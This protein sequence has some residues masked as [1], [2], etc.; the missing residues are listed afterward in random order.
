[1]SNSITKTFGVHPVSFMVDDR[2]HTFQSDQVELAH[3]QLDHLDPTGRATNK[4]IL[5]WLIAEEK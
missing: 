4:A 1:M 2:W 3:K 5:A